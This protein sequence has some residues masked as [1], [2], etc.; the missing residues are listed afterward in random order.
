MPDPERIV[1]SRRRMMWLDPFLRFYV[2][3]R[4]H[5]VL[6]E[7]ELEHDPGAVNVIMA[8]HVGRLDGFIVRMMQRRAAPGARLVTIMLERQL[9]RYP[10]FKRAGAF[11]ITPGSLASARRLKQMV[12]HDLM[13]GDCVALFPQGRIEAVDADPRRIHTGY[14]HV[15]H[16]D[17]TTRFIPVA[18]SVEPLTHS[19]PTVFV[20]IG[21]PVNVDHAGETFAGTVDGLREWLRMHG[22]TAD[23]D[24]PG[25]RLL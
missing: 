18:L 21:A 3:R 11:G 10:V 2:G 1:F 12:S 14:R 15:V 23:S 13:A 20:R 6:V 7:G 17:L 22:E 25:Y 5:G 4:V 24:W 8:Q 9:K 16:P 19:K